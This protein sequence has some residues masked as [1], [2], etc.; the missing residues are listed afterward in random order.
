MGN[1]PLCIDCHTL[2]GPQGQPLHATIED[3][4]DIELASR[5]SYFVW[6]SMPDDELLRLAGEKKL[7]ADIADAIAVAI[8]MV[9]GQ[10]GGQLDTAF[11]TAQADLKP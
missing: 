4:S 9:L 6:S 5:L 2:H 3:L 1:A 10:V 8:V 11:N 7:R